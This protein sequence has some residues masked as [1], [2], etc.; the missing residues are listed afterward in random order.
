V[1][2]KTL[3]LCPTCFIGQAEQKI[4]TTSWKITPED[5]ALDGT[6]EAECGKEIKTIKDI[7]RE[8]LSKNSFDGLYKDE[9]GC[10]LNNLFPCG[11]EY[12]DDCIPGF[13]Y[14]CPEECSCGADQHIGPIQAALGE[15]E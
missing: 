13:T 7:I 2:D 11:G 15:K 3:V 5:Y 4:N 9:C 10:L 14:L 6:S 12:I 1:S 8:H